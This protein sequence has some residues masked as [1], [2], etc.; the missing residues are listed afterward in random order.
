VERLWRK[1]ESGQEDSIYPRLESAIEE[2]S[3][4]IYHYNIE[5]IQAIQTNSFGATPE[6]NARRGKSDP[7]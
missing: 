3:N 6:N 4:M 7:L 5:M 1:D 2:L